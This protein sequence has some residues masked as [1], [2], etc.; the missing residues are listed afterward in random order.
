MTVN[1]SDSAAV[2]AE[3]KQ[4]TQEQERQIAELDKRIA[5]AS[6]ELEKRRT[7]LA[8]K[9]GRTPKYTLAD[10]ED[11]LDSMDKLLSSS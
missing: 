9:S 1:M 2:Y 11:E 3:L 6:Q 8:G 4:K 5:A 7:K 10:L